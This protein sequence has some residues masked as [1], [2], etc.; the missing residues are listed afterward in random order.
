MNKQ[1]NLYALVYLDEIKVFNS[2][3]VQNTKDPNWNQTAHLF[4]K[5]WDCLLELKIKMVVGDD[6]DFSNDPDIAVWKCSGEQMIS[7]LGL[8]PQLV[9]LTSSRGSDTVSVMNLDVFGKLR[10]TGSY[11]PIF[12]EILEG[13]ET[14]KIELEILSAS[15]LDSADIGG[16]S[17][18][19]CSVNLGKEKIFKTK[20]K[21]KDLNPIW[22][23]RVSIDV[24]TRSSTSLTIE[25]M[26]HNS[27][28]KD[29]L[30]GIVTLPLRNVKLTRIE[31]V[32]TI[33]KGKGTLKLAFKFVPLTIAEKNDE[34]ST[35]TQFTR[36][37]FSPNDLVSK[38]NSKLT[39][40][41]TESIEVTVPK[42]I[43]VE[44]SSGYLK[45]GT[46]L[47]RLSEDVESS[48]SAEFSFN[49][50]NDQRLR[51][52]SNE[53]IDS[54]GSR[55]NRSRKAISGLFTNSLSKSRSQT[56]MN[57]DNN[58]GSMTLTIVAAKG[59]LAVDK[60]EAIDSYVKISLVVDRKE[61][62][63]HKTAVIKKN[64]S[65]VW[66]GESISFKLNPGMFHFQIKD[67]NLISSRSLGWIKIDFSEFFEN[68][69]AVD[70]LK[71]FDE[72]FPIVDG[73]GEL[74]LKGELREV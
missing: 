32:F 16:T 48:V 74:H 42:T 23:E 34:H 21:K 36:N 8:P 25:I 44:E 41:K 12:K 7:I 71:K 38:L 72:W 57:E 9:N 1:G 68:I 27:F 65:P 45:A 2:R 73:S 56:K 17:D 10:L 35:V 69:Q 61:K 30:L 14:G 5:S 40:S 6:A 3:V 18:P 13:G 37:F 54:L 59:L 55:S 67:Q 50:L 24:V 49:N 60:S 63:I 64:L 28:S 19:Y 29:S 39:G 22:N 62:L 4:I 53:S 58:A 31:D 66:T 47:D 20:I 70:G 43:K 33:E 51:V 52:M 26:D 11:F 15:N 46:S